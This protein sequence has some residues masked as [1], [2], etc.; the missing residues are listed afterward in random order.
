[1][2]GHVSQRDENGEESQNVQNQNHALEARKHFASDTVDTDRKSNNCPE[3]KCTVPILWLV[4]VI[5]EHDQ[6]LDQGTNKITRCRKRSLPSNDREPAWN[7]VSSSFLNVLEFSV[8]TREVAE[9][10]H[11]RS[12]G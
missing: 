7:R 6:A 10:F 1:M 12:R 9:E 5:G 2:I 3:E 11:A 4:A 8:L